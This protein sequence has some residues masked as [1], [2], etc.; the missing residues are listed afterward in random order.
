[1]PDDDARAADRAADEQ[2]Q[3]VG[4]EATRELPQPSPPP[5]PQPNPWSSPAEG[6]SAP[7]G[8]FPP[9]P[10]AAVQ[11]TTPPQPDNPY[12]Q[13]PGQPERPYGEASPPPPPAYG[14]PPGYGPPPPA[15]GAPPGYGA[16]PAYGPPPG[17]GALSGQPG[18]A[19]SGR[20]QVVLICGVASLVVPFVGW[21]AAIVALVLAGGAK[22]EIE[23]SQGRL[24]GL[25]L[26]KAGRIC[27]WIALALTVLGILALVFLIIVGGAAG[28]FSDSGSITY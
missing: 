9:P 7:P 8:A 22:R 2:T 21:I 26:V 15:Y 23:G 28:G 18:P 13:Q 19:T 10:A 5:S 17:Y 6:A 3:A 14:A 16:P 20:A 27:S 12:A 1:M 24:T 11:G 25:G 4:G